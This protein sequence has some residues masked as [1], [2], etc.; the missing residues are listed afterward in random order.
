MDPEMNPLGFDARQMYQ[1]IAVRFHLTSHKVKEQALRW[2]QVLSK[3]EIVIP[4]YFIFSIF[5]EG[6]R[7]NKPVEKISKRGSVSADN[8]K[9]VICKI[10]VSKYNFMVM[11]QRFSS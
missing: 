8:T 7:V 4:L 6:I 3:L 9:D 2:L 5:R 1:F 11:V 10:H